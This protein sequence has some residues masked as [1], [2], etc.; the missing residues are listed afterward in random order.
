MSDEQITVSKSVFDALQREVHDYRNLMDTLID[1]YQRDWMG[2]KTSA[3]ASAM[4]EYI[5]STQTHIR[6]WQTEALEKARSAHP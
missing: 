2:A 4:R 5:R 6:K 3:P 1:L